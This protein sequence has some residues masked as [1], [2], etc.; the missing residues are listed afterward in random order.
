M[1][2]T[3]F[4]DVD[5]QYDFIMP[6]GKLYIQEAEKILPNLARLTANARQRGVPIFGSVDYHNPEDPEISE[7]PDFLNTF[8]PHCLK[9]TPGQLKVPET[10]PVNPLWID[11]DAEDPMALSQRIRDHT[12]EV[13]FRKQRFDVFTNRNVEPV[14]DMIR[15]DRI[16][17]YGVALDVCNAHAINGF[18][19]RN[20]AA[21]ELVLDAAQAISTERGEALVDGWKTRGVAVVSADEITQ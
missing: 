10:R 19:E 1:H 21:I 12:G 18:L 13:I 3:I 8:P 11:G 7:A 4:W 9:G 16:V 5:T 20:T 17:L 2:D 6:G 14:L 15:P